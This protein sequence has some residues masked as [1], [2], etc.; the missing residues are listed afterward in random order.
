[1][2]KPPLFHSAPIFPSLPTLPSCHAST[3]L[4]LPDGDLLVAF[5]AG[6]VEKAADVSILLC[7]YV[8]AEN[9]WCSPELLVDMPSRSVGN[10]LLFRHRS[11]VIHLYYLVMEGN[12]WH[13]CTIHQ[14]TSTDGGLTWGPSTLF[15]AA[16]GWTTRNNLIVLQ[17]GDLLFP[18]SDNVAGCSVM[19][20]S[21]DGGQTWQEAGRI[22]SSPANEQPAVV[23]LDD[24]SLL[25]YMR[26]GGKGGACWESR[27]TDGGCT[28]S[29]AQPGPFK[30]PNSAMAMIRHTGGG[31][32]TVYNDSDHYRYRTP[33]KVA[34]SLD[35]G[36]SWPFVRVLEDR[37]G[38]FTYL[39]TRLD[40]SDS[41]EYSYPAIAESA[42]GLVHVT[43][44]NCRENIKETLFNLA[45]LKEGC[46]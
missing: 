14:R 13:H 18:L 9:A 46:Q 25:A 6:S 35:Q 42:D 10:P 19:L 45:W 40:N 30:N 16:P 38:E 11:G 5:Y 37:P 33:L 31:L 41:I 4:A 26:T 23:Q 34:L 20:R 3:L 24:G 39:T 1:M 7:R 44:T 8:A 32:V 12:K 21:A 22:P 27:S 28:W 2:S 15:R 36:A 17:E 43:Y 29:K